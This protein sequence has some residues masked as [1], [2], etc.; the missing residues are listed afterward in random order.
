MNFGEKLKQIR[1]D[2]NMTQPQMAE[3]IGIEQSYLSK[4]ENDKSVPSAE[5]FQ[6]IIKNLELDVRAFLADI[7][8]S[9][10]HGA[11]RQIPEVAQFIQGTK[12]QET[13]RVQRWLY[14]STLACVLGATLIVAGYM[15]LILPKTNLVYFSKG[16][17]KAD[18]PSDVLDKVAKYVLLRK[19]AVNLS[20]S[21]H[22]RLVDEFNFQRKHEA[23]KNVPR[24][25]GYEF[26]EKITQGEFVGW[27]RHWMRTG[28]TQSINET[29]NNLIVLLGVFLSFAGLFGFV[30]EFRLRRYFAARP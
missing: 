15:G 26:D 6:S 20:D 27:H 2:K 11:M 14:T 3:A 12:Q 23:S 1:T 4:L 19:D 21:E 5:M 24:D 29:E 22:A 28:M 8:Q 25:L 18:E 30:L 7:D 10:L 16:L 9:I 17:M 13:H